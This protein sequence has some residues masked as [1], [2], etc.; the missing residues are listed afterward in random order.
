VDG[1]TKKRWVCV[2]GACTF[3]QAVMGV[4]ARKVRLR[5]DSHWTHIG[6]GWYGLKFERSCHYLGYLKPHFKV[7]FAYHKFLGF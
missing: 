1:P 5:E 7:A 4:L 3:G 6:V 2:W